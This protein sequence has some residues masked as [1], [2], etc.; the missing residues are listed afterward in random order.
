[1]IFHFALKPYS[2]LKQS[3]DPSFGQSYRSAPLL[4]RAAVSYATPRRAWLCFSTL[5][6][7]LGCLHS[8]VLGEAATVDA[9]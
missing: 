4:K 8:G 1:M 7:Q 3:L 5:A 2:D 6:R 9:D